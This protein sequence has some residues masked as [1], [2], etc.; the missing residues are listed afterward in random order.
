MIKA[1]LIDSNKHIPKNIIKDIILCDIFAL[2]KF[3]CDDYNIK[4]V[5][6]K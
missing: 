3:M 5:L 1:N 2:P 4:D 6:K